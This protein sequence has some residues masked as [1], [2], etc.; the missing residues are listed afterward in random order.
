MEFAAAVVQSLWSIL[1]EAGWW[2]IAGFGV[3]GLLHALVPRR[4]LSRQLGRGGV[5]SVVKG[6]VIGAPLPLCSCAVIPAA[7]ALRRGGAGRGASAA[8]AVAT[9]EVDAPS[10]A[11]TWAMMGPVMAVARPLSALASAI[12]AGLLVDAAGEGAGRGATSAKG[13]A[14]TAAKG[15]C[16]GGGA[17]RPEPEASCCATTEPKDTGRSVG[18]M[19]SPASSPP[20]AAPA[21][22]SCCSSTAA[23]AP[24]SCC[25]GAEGEEAVARAARP[26]VGSRLI[27]ALRY[28]YL[29][30][31]KMLAGWI[32]VG[33][34]LSAIVA[35]AVPVGWIEANL[36]GDSP[37]G[38]FGQKLVMLVIGQPLYV[39]AT[40]STPLAAVLVAKGL[41]P[42]AA[43][44]F[45]LAGPATN[46]ATMGWALKD[47]GVRGLVAYLSA[48]SFIA[49]GAG[50]TL[51]ALLPAAWAEAIVAK[52]AASMVHHHH[53]GTLAGL[54]GVLL[55]VLLGVG[56]LR[57]FV[58]ARGGSRVGRAAA[59]A[60]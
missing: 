7:A 42:G 43:L 11:V 21:A 9:P 19:I 31:P 17:G 50:V 35:A 16:C 38:A 28:G 13:R 40:A 5:W 29:H 24:A 18:L 25:G 52:S 34:V 1:V 8:F 36:G 30:L 37:M 32:V 49:L 56:L 12:T 45:L 27:E 14:G 2:L 59:A 39:C 48:I 6:A 4:W 15:S 57:K 3:A 44:V 46:P 55:S 53:A 41:T 10:V 20:P 54:G 51:D 26:G 33:I 60:E 47:L 58:P 23:A 22:K